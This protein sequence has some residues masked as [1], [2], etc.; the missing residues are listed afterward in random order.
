MGVVEH[1]QFFPK[2]NE[3]K[4]RG[5]KQSGMHSPRGL[6]VWSVNFIL[7]LM[8]QIFSSFLMTFITGNFKLYFI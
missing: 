5:W 3:L 6:M 7:S 8:N 1:S 4:E 2:K